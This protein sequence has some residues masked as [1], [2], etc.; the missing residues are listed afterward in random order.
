MWHQEENL[1]FSPV[2]TSSQSMMA[3]RHM[4]RRNSLG[5]L[6][7]AVAK[8]TFQTGGRCRKADCGWPG[9]HEKP[10]F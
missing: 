9:C 3:F 1:T 5:R 10:S 6:P 8:G 7:E 4:F 2:H